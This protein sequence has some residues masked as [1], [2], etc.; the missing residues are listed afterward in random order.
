[1]VSVEGS[2]NADSAR[3][4]VGDTGKGIPPEILANIFSPY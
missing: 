2:H 4:V 1:M 3:L